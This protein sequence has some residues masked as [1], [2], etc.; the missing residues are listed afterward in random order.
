MPVY[1]PPSGAA[2]DFDLSTGVQVYN[3]PSGMYVDF[4]HTILEDVYNP[5]IDTGSLSSGGVSFGGRASVGKDRLTTG[6][7]NLRLGFTLPQ[8]GASLKIVN[9]PN[10]L[11]TF[12]VR[13]IPPRGGYDSI[14]RKGS[15][16][17]GVGVKAAIDHYI[18]ELKTKTEITVHGSV[19]GGP[20]S[21]RAVPLP[22]Q[23]TF[24]G[25]TAGGIFIT[26][27]RS[28][29]TM[30][31]GIKAP[32][33]KEFMD[34]GGFSPAVRLGLQSSS[35]PFTQAAQFGFRF[36]GSAPIST[37]QNEGNT[38][39]GVT[40][41]TRDYYTTEIGHYVKD[42]QIRTS[43]V[44]DGKANG[45]YDKVPVKTIFRITHGG[46]AGGDTKSFKVEAKSRLSFGGRASPVEDHPPVFVS[47]PETGIVPGRPYSYTPV[48]T[49]DYSTPT[50]HGG[51]LPSFLTFA[52]GKLTGTP[53]YGTLDS[54]IVS[55][56]A[57]DDIGSVT[58]QTYILEVLSPFRTQD[59]RDVRL[60][61]DNAPARVVTADLTAKR[62]SDSA[63]KHFYF[64][65]DAYVS[66]PDDSPWNQ[67]FPPLIKDIPAFNRS[68]DV[69]EYRADTSW[70]EITVINSGH[71]DPLLTDYT[72]RFRP[73]TI[74]MGERL[75]PYKNF[76]T[77]IQGCLGER[78]VTASSPS[79]LSLPIRSNAILLEVALSE[80][81]WS[82]EDKL[83]PE[84]VKPECWGGSIECPIFNIAPVLIDDANHRYKYHNGKA[85]GVVKVRDLGIDIAFQDFPAVGEFELLHPPKGDI[86]ADVVGGYSKDGKQYGNLVELLYSL[87]IDKSPI[88][89]DMIDTTS[90][91]KLTR[92][93]R[94][95]IGGFYYP[96]GGSATVRDMATWMMSSINSYFEFRRD[97][98]MYVREMFEQ[99]FLTQDASLLPDYTFTLDEISKDITP[100]DILPAMYEV[101]FGWK[102]NWN[103]QTT[104]ADYIHEEALS[105][106][107]LYED[108]HTK[109]V[110]TNPAVQSKIVKAEKMDVW[111][112]LLLHEETAN[113]AAQLRADL[114]AKDRR[115]YSIKVFKL[116]SMLNLGDIIKVESS[117][118]NI[119]NYPVV[120]IGIEDPIVTQLGEVK[121]IQ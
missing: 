23:I 62:W 42:A 39:M 52:N 120:T 117:R 1:N 109:I 111:E 78:G 102:K 100:E 33:L 22:G 68:L 57:R 25:L 106:K 7:L 43:I 26:D 4:D 104:F 12:T 91:S 98:N 76:I 85:G 90:F 27:T 61:L 47:R 108:P 6:A 53:P 14:A 73:I 119:G 64:S 65:N 54:L 32:A 82:K 99:G 69:N 21:T 58:T 11:Y 89:T 30:K 75:I 74:K 92:M 9:L 36:N 8:A 16:T 84:K 29:F 87:V 37:V 59:L 15:F 110:K 63:D 38:R 72:S 49:D 105:L 97:G 50:V 18:K 114:R 20:D 34:I 44:F 116:A 46:T 95:A 93:Y 81:K 17:L 66:W 35:T 5:Y 31:L 113:L 45:Y 115:I 80:D 48:V 79:I 19:R 56:Y 71:L 13:S 10:S 107:T 41:K 94:N 112:S 40:L 101:P 118:F 2:A 55:L 88:T 77:V 24:S 51:Y 103:P 83:N 3:P 86:T 70:G 96:E 67:S 28:V 60:Y 121:V